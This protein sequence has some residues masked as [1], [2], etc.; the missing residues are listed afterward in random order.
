MLT[1][2]CCIATE[3]KGLYPD[4]SFDPT[5]PW[6]LYTAA[7]VLVPSIVPYTLLVMKPSTLDPLI[8]AAADPSILST[9][10]TLEL[11]QIWKGQN[12]VRQAFGAAGS[13]LGAIATVMMT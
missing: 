2:M 3:R 7:A 13:L 10:R 5:A 6:A 8:A 1:I 4:M 11:L 12:Y 9:E